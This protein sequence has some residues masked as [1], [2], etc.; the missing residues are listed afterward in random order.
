[1]QLVSLRI[2]SCV[3]RYI[4]L[5]LRWGGRSVWLIH[6]TEEERGTERILIFNTRCAYNSCIKCIYTWIGILVRENRDAYYTSSRTEVVLCPC[7]FAVSKRATKKPSSPPPQQQQEKSKAPRSSK[8]A[9]KHDTQQQ[10]RN[11]K[12]CTAKA[13]PWG[14][15]SG[16]LLL[17]LLLVQQRSNTYFSI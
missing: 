3:A 14:K 1:M 15:V 2:L 11:Q 17:Y 13:P 9:N 12:G 4:R 8:A 5:S 10:S 7:V 6:P 16:P